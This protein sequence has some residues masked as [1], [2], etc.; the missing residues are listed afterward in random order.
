MTPSPEIARQILEKV[1]TIS[2]PFGTQIAIENNVGVI[3]VASGG[4]SHRDLGGN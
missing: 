4:A 3:H 2:K 1:Q